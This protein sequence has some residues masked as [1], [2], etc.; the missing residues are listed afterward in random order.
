MTTVVVFQFTQS[1]VGPTDVVCDA[2]PFIHSIDLLVIGV[3]LVLDLTVQLQ[4]PSVYMDAST[5]SREFK[6]CENWDFPVFRNRGDPYMKR[7]R[8]S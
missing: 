3:V 2:V 7:Q 6:P 4:R 5:E 8:Y 1:P